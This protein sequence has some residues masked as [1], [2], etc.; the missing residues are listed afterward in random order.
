MGHLV[1]VDLETSGLDPEV[2]EIIEVGL[3]YMQHV[4]DIEIVQEVEFSLP[5]DV[6]QANPEAL[7]ING[8]SPSSPNHRAFP[9]FLS[10]DEACKFLAELLDDAHLIGKN[11]GSFDSLFLKEF[12]KRHTG[13][14]YGV[15]PMWHHR[16]VDVGTL[17]MGRFRLE[18]PPNTETVER[19]TG[20]K[21]PEGQRHTALADAKWAWDVFHYLVKS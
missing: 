1:A 8:W 20:I 13:W 12:F 15:K 5:F 4:D 11:P 19:A 17:T 3:V 2:H 16:M 21:I 9:E 6:K 14:K 7:Q 10:T 18:D